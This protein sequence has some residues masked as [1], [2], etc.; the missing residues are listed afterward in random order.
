MIADETQLDYT[1]LATLLAEAAESTKYELYPRIESAVGEVREFL[2]AALDALL[3]K[4]A[5]PVSYELLPRID[6][7]VAEVRES[8]QAIEHRDDFVT[9]QSL[10]V[11]EPETLAQLESWVETNLREYMSDGYY[12]VGA[13]SLV[14]KPYFSSA[15][16][17]ALAL[18]RAATLIGIPRVIELL[19]NWLDCVPLSFA[20][21]SLIF[22]LRLEAPLNVTEDINLT[23]VGFRLGEFGP[24]LPA[25]VKNRFGSFERPQLAN[26]VMISIDQEVWH[27]DTLF[28][29]ESED[30]EEE[31]EEE[32]LFEER[33]RLD[34]IYR[35]LS[36]ATNSAVIPLYKWRDYGDLL[37]FNTGT[38]NPSMIPSIESSEQHL[39]RSKRALVSSTQMT[40]AAKLLPSLNAGDLTSL[41]LYQAVERWTKAKKLGLSIT[42]WTMADSF[43][44]LRIVLEGLFLKD[45]RET[46][47][48]HKISKRA[49]MVSGKNAQE[50]QD[51]EQKVE[52]LYVIGSEAVHKGE[53]DAGRRNNELLSFGLNLAREEILDRLR[54][55]HRR[56]WDAVT[57]G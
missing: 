54:T 37:A 9:L 38:L 18:V 10:P 4:V 57:L 24:D 28:T 52:T 43:I 14:S 26:A 46:R 31:T 49:A 6:F 8:W 42:D 25:F 17:V 44:E 35:A 41:G 23:P 20:T 7:T 12:G 53:L 33:D 36:L 47:K 39:V 15:I 3:P 27:V 2:E 22:G 34:A 56:D 5:K 32:F 51:I 55:G 45:A 30:L 48:T 29:P 19:Q 16:E 21:K 13:L 11:V 40:L 1:S 50:V